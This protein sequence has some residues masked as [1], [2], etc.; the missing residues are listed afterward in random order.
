MPASM[1]WKGKPVVVRVDLSGLWWTGSEIEGEEV[2][3]SCVLRLDMGE[4]E[5]RLV[6]GFLVAG[7]TG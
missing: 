1:G 3:G 7:S 5:A 6:L 2:V 4:S